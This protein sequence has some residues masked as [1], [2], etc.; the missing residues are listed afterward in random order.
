MSEL[1]AIAHLID[2]PVWAVSGVVKERQQDLEIAGSLPVSTFAPLINLIPF[3]DDLTVSLINRRYIYRD[4]QV[5]AAF[6][7]A[8]GEAGLFERD[9]DQLS[10]APR[11]QALANEVNATVD[12]IC[13]EL[14]GA[15]D[16]HALSVSKMARRVLDAATDRH[17][18]VGFA[19]RTTEPTDTLH[20]LW[21]RLTALRLVRN[22]AHVAAW[23]DVGL[24]PN[25]VEVLTSA[26]AGTA[27]QGDSAPSQGLIERGFVTDGVVNEEG[28]RVRQQIEDATDDGVRQAYAA[29]DTSRFLDL[30]IDLAPTA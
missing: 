26:W 24:T 30:L 28:L 27:T 12:I 3:R 1:T 22:E 25:D 4:P 17:G 14:W 7:E 9:G 8:L 11:V 21:S 10:A 18:L 29:I 15:D 19:Q 2:R 13:S 6:V 5:T 20:Q 23:T 16:E